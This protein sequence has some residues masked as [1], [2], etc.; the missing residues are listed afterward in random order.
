[1]IVLK[2]YQEVIKVFFL[3]SFHK[4]LKSVFLSGKKRQ[5]LEAGWEGKNEFAQSYIVTQLVR[6]ADLNSWLFNGRRELPVCVLPVWRY[7][8][9]Q[10]RSVQHLLFL[11]R[12]RSHPHRRCCSA[13]LSKPWWEQACWPGNSQGA[14]VCRLALPLL[15]CFGTLKE[16][17]HP[18]EKPVLFGF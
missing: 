11:P 4:N 8:P 14:D 18:L 5:S 13:Q 17:S 6:E 1:M 2:T 10:H 9:C 15:A 3:F 12:A 7:G 16:K